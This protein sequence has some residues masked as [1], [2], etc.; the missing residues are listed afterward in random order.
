MLPIGTARIERSNQVLSAPI[1]SG[2]CVPYAELLTALTTV[3]RSLHPASRRVRGRDEVSYSRADLFGHLSIGDDVTQSIQIH[4]FENGLVLVAQQMKWLESA[5]ISVLVPAGCSRDPANLLGLS[6]MTCEMVQRGCG[7]RDSRQFIN[8]LENL[9]VDHSASVANAHTSFGGAMTA[10]KLEQAVEIYA[11]LVQRPHLP[12]GQ[13]ED[14]RLACLQEIYALDDDLAQRAMLE[15]RRR[16]YGDP[17]GRHSPGTAAAVEQINLDDIQRHFACH[18]RPNGTIISA[19]GNIDFARL[20]DHVGNLFGDWRP[21]K[22]PGL[23]DV[24]GE[25]TPTHIQHE[26]SQTHIAIAYPCVRYGDDDYYQARGA[27]G[28]LSDGMSSRL[29]TEVR[30]NRGLCY[31]VYATCHSVK[32]RGC[33]ICYAGT[34]TERA[35]ETLDVVIRELRQLASGVRADELQRLQTRLKSAL[36]MQQESSAARAGSIAADWYYLGRVQTLEEVRGIVEGLTCGSINTYL[37]AHPPAD[38]L[39][40]TLG[41][42]ALEIP[43]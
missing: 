5:A 17:F 38:F 18:Y 15:L 9:G 31:A 19:A 33:V 35:Q 11:D 8:D 22:E 39:L 14:S 1:E 16:E 32:D 34:S 3:G 37:A 7:E 6:N 26:S 27:V 23:V 30:E 13:V 12:A 21:S 20:R 28:V 4:T 10:D 41:Q 25:R 29:F 42:Q 2:G 36:I 40:V 43:L 24:P